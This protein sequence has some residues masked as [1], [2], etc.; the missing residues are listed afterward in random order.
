MSRLAQVI[1][2]YL[3]LLSCFSTGLSAQDP[4]I[5]VSN[6]E[7]QMPEHR[8]LFYL[9]RNELVL[10]EL[11]LSEKK[12]GKLEPLLKAI[13]DEHQEHKERV[14]KKGGTITRKEVEELHLFF[15]KRIRTEQ[16]AIRTLLSD[17]DKKRLR[18][19][20]FQFHFVQTIR[21]SG[22]ESDYRHI[23]LDK[24]IAEGLSISPMQLTVIRESYQQLDAGLAKLES[25]DS[26]RLEELLSS[27]HESILE[28]LDAKQRKCYEDVIGR[29]AEAL[30]NHNSQV[31]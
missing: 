28:A 12:T 13:D 2:G 20:A 3:L 30:N 18:Q 11:E 6:F 7:K 22:K 1:F 19:I 27:F 21:I 29:P 15:F 25:G 14:R 5:D 23:L 8:Y 9:L 26:K 4:K 24:K 16:E 17:Q 10:A 31:P